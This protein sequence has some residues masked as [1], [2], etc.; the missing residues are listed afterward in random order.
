[1]ELALTREPGYFPRSYWFSGPVALSLRGKE[2]GSEGEKGENFPYWPSR[3]AWMT[4]APVFR[5][6][7]ARTLL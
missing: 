7:H 6:P 4:A 3:L 5:G 2:K 1:M